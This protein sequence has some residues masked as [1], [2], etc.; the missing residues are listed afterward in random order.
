MSKKRENPS[1]CADS[2]WGH[3]GRAQH[4]CRAVYGRNQSVR[5]SIFSCWSLVNSWSIMGTYKEYE[6]SKRRK[7][8]WRNENGNNRK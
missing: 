3:L 8:E 5:S 1:V 4:V 6:K 2:Y 7:V